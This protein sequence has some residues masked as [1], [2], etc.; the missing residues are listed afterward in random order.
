MRQHE[1]AD[2]AQGLP[3]TLVPRTAPERALAQAESDK[4]LDA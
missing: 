1:A 3:L 2:K 4:V